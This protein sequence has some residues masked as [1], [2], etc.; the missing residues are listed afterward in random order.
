MLYV[1]YTSNK[2]A[3]TGRE[4]GTDGKEKEVRTTGF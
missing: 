3:M 2:V 4:Q 1:N